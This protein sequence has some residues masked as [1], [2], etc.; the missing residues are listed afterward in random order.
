M[1]RAKQ[2]VLL[3]YH[4]RKDRY[5]KKTLKY[6]VTYN[7]G[8]SDNDQQIDTEKHEE[9]EMGKKKLDLS[10]PTSGVLEKV[11]PVSDSDQESSDEE[12]EKKANELTQ[13]QQ[14]LANF[15]KFSDSLLSKSAKLHKL[16][17]ELEE[18]IPDIPDGADKKKANRTVKALEDVVGVL[19]DENEK[20]E[21]CRA[22]CA[23]LTN[24]SLPEEEFKRLA[25]KLDGQMQKTTVTTNAHVPQSVSILDLQSK[26]QEKPGAVLEPLPACSDT[27]STKPPELEKAACK[28]VV[29]TAS[30]AVAEDPEGGHT[31]ALRELSSVS[32][33]DAETGVHRVFRKYGLAADLPLKRAVIG[34]G[35]LAAFPYLKFSDW[36]RY[37]IERKQLGQLCGTNDIEQMNVLLSEFWRRYKLVEPEH[38]LWALAAANQVDLKFCLPIYS[39]TDEGRTLKKKPFWILSCHGALGAGTAKNIRSVPISPANIRE[40]GMRLNFL[41]NTWGTQFLVSVMTRQLQNEHPASMQKI[42]AEF[43]KDMQMLISKGVTSKDGN[44]KI[45][46]V[47][48]ANKGDLPAL[49]RL[50]HFERNYARCP[51]APSSKTECIGI[52]HLC[53]AGVEGPG[54]TALHPWEDF[55]EGASWRDTLYQQVPWETEPEVLMG[56]PTVRGAAESFFVVDVWHTFHYG[57]A[58]NYVG[59][60]MIHLITHFFDDRSWPAK[61]A[62]LSREY[63]SFC[64]RQRLTPYLNEINEYTFNYESEKAFPLGHW[65]KG[66]VS[67]N[68]MLFLEDLLQRIPKCANGFGTHWQKQYKCKKIMWAG[69]AE[70]HGG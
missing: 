36:V 8:D 7:E 67:T 21:K 37:L 66:A 60:A 5:N 30:A 63:F 15:K 29:E 46:C 27:H 56:V 25:G 69:R 28:H 32:L 70:S 55:R 43:A 51:K 24:K 42:V 38:E 18:Y 11:A 44:L 49:I 58:R 62:H 50:G 17:A 12:K 3:C 6:Y 20:M 13:G 41:G 26:V 22:E 53:Q 64:Q 65:S 9:Q 54:N 34:P 1:F 35:P 52:C 47:H 16:L 39:H 61:F 19:E 33:T 48:L 14:E 10:G 40:D 57:I 45:W 31:P 59:S 23:Q 4:G 2:H 68:M